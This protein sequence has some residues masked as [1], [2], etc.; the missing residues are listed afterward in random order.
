M[1]DFGIT[2]SAI[3]I[4][5]LRLQRTAIAQ[6][7]NWV[8]P[9]LA[10][11]AKGQR[12][13]CSSDEDPITM[14]VSAG[15]DC[16]LQNDNDEIQSL[17]FASTSAPFIDRQH[18][19]LI[20]EAVNLNDSVTTLDVSS[21]MRAGT[22]ALLRQLQQDASNTQSLLIASDACIPKAGNPAEM[23]DG[24]GAAAVVTGSNPIAAFIA[25]ESI[26]IDLVDHYRTPQ[27]PHNYQ[28]EERWVRDEGINQ[29]LPKVIKK[30]LDKA[31]VAADTIDHLVL[32]LSNT[33]TAGALA[34]KAG[35]DNAKLA[36]NLINITGICGCAH[37]LV[38]LH[39]ILLSAKPDQTILLIGFGQGADAILLK[40][41]AK[42]K[43]QQSKMQSISDGTTVESYTRYLSNKQLLDM[44]WGMRAERDNRTAMSVYYRKRRS[45]NTF[46]GGRC[47][48]CETIQFPMAKLCVNPDCGAYETQQEYCLQNES[49]QVKSFTE[50]WLAHSTNP[51]LKYGNVQ[52]DNG[53]NVMMEFTDFEVGELAVGVQVT[54]R[55]RIKDIDQLRGFR[56]YFWKAAPAGES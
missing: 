22:S 44:D 3:S 51:P 15:N 40:T 50:D 46:I 26:S 19:T 54:P 43:Q 56:R 29:I 21:S 4:P 9:G 35:L 11:R 23:I 30:L 36:D 31:K 27:Q 24:D 52:F 1:T 2:A 49:A 53:A 7:H 41:T 42:L 20:G 18:A 39:Q 47:E 16:L 32:P 28:Y 48:A 37:P 25:A 12:A 34:K 13:F 6:A 10:A 17:T 5:R 8:N 38:M 14:A 55:F 33:R 45:I